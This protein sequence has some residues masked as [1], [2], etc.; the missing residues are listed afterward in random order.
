MNTYNIQNL[1]VDVYTY[2]Q[3]THIRMNTSRINIFVSIHICMMVLCTLATVQYTHIHTCNIQN[4]YV[5]VY[6]YIYNGPMHHSY[7]VRVS[8]SLSFHLGTYRCGVT[9]RKAAEAFYNQEHK[10]EA[11]RKVVVM[12]RECWARRQRQEGKGAKVSR[13]RA[14]L[15][16]LRVRREVM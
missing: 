7:N 14:H 5:R 6:T 1:Y 8:S 11:M 13:A 2:M 16:R 4:Q 10:V 12:Q 9:G 3:Y 15:A